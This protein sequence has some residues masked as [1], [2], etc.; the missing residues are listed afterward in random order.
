MTTTLIAPRL[1]VADTPFFSPWM[2]TDEAARYTR[3]STRT[4][5]GYR[6]RGGGPAYH[7]HDGRIVFYHRDDL[8]AW[9][10]QG[11]TENTGQERHNGVPLPGIP[12]TAE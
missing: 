3:C 7:R 1:C 6:I 11:R 9:R 12:A 10:R 2:T 8:D 5:E 4:L